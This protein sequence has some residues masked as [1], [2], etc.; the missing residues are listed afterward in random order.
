MKYILEVTTKKN[1]KKVYTVK[2]ENGVVIS[3]RESF[4]DYVAAEIHG[5]NYF[6]RVDLAKSYQAKYPTAVIAYLQTPAA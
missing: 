5:N 4:R 3:D 2:D 1:G 6:G